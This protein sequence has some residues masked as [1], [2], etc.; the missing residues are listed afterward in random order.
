MTSKLETWV[1]IENYQGVYRKGQRWLPLGGG[2]LEH[3]KA[4]A[5]SKISASLNDWKLGW[6]TSYQSDSVLKLNEWLNQGVD[7]NWQIQKELNSLGFFFFSF[8]TYFSDE[9]WWRASTVTMFCF[10]SP[11]WIYVPIKHL[12][13][14]KMFPARYKHCIF[15]RKTC[16]WCPRVRYLC[17]ALC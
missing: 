17:T 13:K 6:Q 14:I 10:F 12:L 15:L 2:S 16:Q 4:G 11:S 9:S 8:R 5:Y 1:V 3:S 7:W